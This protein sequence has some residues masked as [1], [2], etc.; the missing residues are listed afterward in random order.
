MGTY[1]VVANQ[2]AI[3][4]ELV[5]GLRAKRNEDSSAEFFLVVPATPIA[6]RNPS[7]VPMG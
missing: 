7:S 2:T 5:A 3:S 1:L 4:D 6:I